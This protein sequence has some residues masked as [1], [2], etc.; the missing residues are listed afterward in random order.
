MT[1]SWI[2]QIH[3]AHA[4]SRR[5]AF[6]DDTGV[7]NG[8][9]LIGTAVCAAEFLL[10]LNGPAGIGVPALATTNSRTMA[11]LLGGA[12]TARPLAPVGPRMSAAELTE[13]ITQSESPVLLF[14]TAFTGMATEVANRAGIRAVAIPHLRRSATAFPTVV[15]DVAFILHTA[16]TTGRPKPVGI[17]DEVLHHRARLLTE[18]VG[19][20][21]DTTYATGSPI[22]HIGGVGNLLAALTAGGAAVSTTRFSTQWWSA[23][24]QLGVTHALL[25]PTMIEML[26]TAGV[27]DEVGLRTL[28]YGAAPI[29]PTTLRRVIDLL[30]STNLVN[31]FGQ[32]EGSPITCLDA[33]DHRRALAQPDLLDSVG[34]AVPGLQLRI[35]PVDN[36]GAGEVLA[37]APHLSSVDRDGWLHTG[38]IGELDP[39]GYL[40]LRS[41]RHDMI[42]RGGE[43]VYPVDIENVVGAHPKVKNVGVVGVRDDRLGETIAAFVVPEVTDDQPHPDELHAWSRARMAGFKVPTHWYI[44]AELP[45][46]ATGKLLRTR[47][48]S[49]HDTNYCN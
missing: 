48:R 9:D 20:G 15:N 41:R 23:L 30:P 25:V 49:W 7:L 16:G 31:L 38:D 28:I 39:N 35:E 27:M 13:L 5:P 29:R 10:D 19:F 36:S 21:P 34:R 6:H 3:A 12:V 11:L 47:L 45:L 14:E 24:R 2:E 1:T 32:T 42:V 44:V 46:S 18:V 8:A 17:T 40:R 4:G 43:N 33:E 37:S 26:V 22:H